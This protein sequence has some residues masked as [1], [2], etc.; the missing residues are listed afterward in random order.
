[1]TR[2]A[3]IQALSIIYES[4]NQV[5]SKQSSS[6]CRAES[7]ATAKFEYLEV[8]DVC[9]LANTYMCTKVKKT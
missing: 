1:M 4:I 5:W 6:V 2:S 8:Q 9:S 7:E 3:G